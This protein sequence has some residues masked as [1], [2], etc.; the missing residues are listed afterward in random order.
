MAERIL[1]SPGVTSREIDLSAP[2]T[3]KPQ[4]VPAGVIGT[5]Q[6]GP[7]FVPKLFATANDF[8]SLFGDSAGAYM[9]P[10]AM[11][12]WM[13]NAR[14]GLFLRTLGVGDAK[15]AD[16]DG[17]TYRAGFLVGDQLVD[18]T[19]T[20]NN[21]FEQAGSVWLPRNLNPYAGDPADISGDTLSVS[22]VNGTPEVDGLDVLEIV[23]DTANV[24]VRSDVN[25]EWFIYDNDTN[26]SAP[27][28]VYLDATGAAVLNVLVVE[29]EDG[30]PIIDL[31][32]QGAVSV[33]IVDLTS[34]A[35]SAAGIATAIVNALA[36]STQSDDGTVWTVSLDLTTNGSLTAN[37]TGNLSVAVADGFQAATASVIT[38]TVDDAQVLDGTLLTVTQLDS[39]PFVFEFDTDGSVDAS[40]DATIDI[41]TAATLDAVRDAIGTAFTVAGLPSFTNI[42]VSNPAQVVLT[43]AIPAQ[44]EADPI[45]TETEPG[46]GESIN[47]STRI[48]GV[49][50]KTP[51]NAQDYL[52]SDTQAAVNVVRAVMMFPRG[53]NPGL[54]AASNATV[55]A[56]PIAFGDF[57]EGRDGGATIGDVGGV[58]NTF[59]VLLNGFANT[60]NY[61]NS[62]T[63]SFDPTSPIYFAKVFNTDPSK[64]EER[65]H[66]LYAHYDIPSGFAVVETAAADKAFLLDSAWNADGED[67]LTFDGTGA[68]P[69]FN[70]W[71]QKFTTA[72]TPWI[73]SQ[74]L[75]DA[76]QN[77]F[78]FHALDDGSAGFDKMKISVSG[79]TKSS[80]TSNPYGRFDILIRS[81]DDSDDKPVV[82]QQF[83]GL[84]LNPSSDRY[85]A[86]VIGDQ[87]TFFDFEKAEGKQKLVTE[88]LY[89]NQSHLVRVEVNEDVENGVMEPSA[90][91]VGFRGKNHL[92]LSATALD[93]GTLVEPPLPMRETVSVGSGSTKI[94]DPRFFWGVQSQDVR[95]VSTRNKNTEVVSLVANLTKHFPSLGGDASMWAGEGSDADAYN[96][97]AFSLENLWVA[98]KSGDVANPVDST[99]WHEAVY[100]RDISSFADGVL[101]TG[102]VLQSVEEGPN[103][104][105]D[106]NTTE[107]YRFLDVAKDFGQ[108][109]AKKFLKFSVP[110]QGGWDGLDIF[111]REKSEMS[112]LSALREMDD[113]GSTVYGGPEGCTTAAFRK[114]LDILAEKSDVDV[115]ILATPGMRSEG[116]TDYGVDKT[117]D[118]FD[119]LYIM[120]TMAIDHNGQWVTNSAQEV[121]VTNTAQSLADR[122]LDTSFAACYFP[123]LVMQDGTTSVVVPPSVA[124]LGA[125][126]LNDAIAHPWYAPAG[127]ARGA[128]PTTIETAV[129][130]N[131][132]NMDVLYESDIN[133]ITSFPQ[134][135]ESVVIF[136]QKTMLQSQSALDR[137]NVR[138]LLIDIRRKVREVSKGILFEPNRETTLSRFSGL[139]N[140]I[141]QRVQAQNGLDRFKVVIDTTTTTQQDVENNTIRGKIFLQP[142]KSIEFVSLDFVVGN[143]G[144]D[145]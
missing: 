98:C 36:T 43:S 75:G 129:K 5:A 32:Q 8:V 116:I 119:A 1:K 17:V 118:R 141:L 7:A 108:S 50:M 137:V 60:A 112:N 143:Q 89:A 105:T 40:S 69:N 34:E 12:E 123:D 124:V 107:G 61:S 38:I 73:V 135:G 95:N 122:N 104:S 133:P 130:L 117:E 41:S 94:V 42:D 3:V 28:G 138:R 49:S 52:G 57:Q 131:R 121:S 20:D 67:Q 51:D 39:T 30:N 15:K 68:K 71:K 85:I 145:I 125:L 22:S 58:D 140:P 70:N 82:L 14:A 31:G 128:L 78:K 80:D 45:V 93:G 76:P 102:G 96:N 18:Y 23:V 144:M 33:I 97:N 111:D 62:L 65:G 21:G 9:G 90:L 120:D 136:G 110:F 126:S 109:A 2:G 53:I 127:F 6:K 77:L 139:V 63:A 103:G 35:D 113:G 4:G 84:S 47:G 59:T 25:T 10:L 74:K 142:T 66:Y 13:R 83:S 16:S 79:I 29:D 72:S 101:V 81:A 86:R 27:V 56:S 44:G 46:N 11:K 54:L 88:G 19:D 87:H 55:E 26:A 92:R 134:T 114:G 106:K 24:N 99:M 91:P 132:P 100:V 115:Q 48:L 64:L 37:G